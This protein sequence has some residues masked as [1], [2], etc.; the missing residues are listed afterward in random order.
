MRPIPAE[1][2]LRDED[3]IN[4]YVD[5]ISRIYLGKPYK[6]KAPLIPENLDY[7][8]GGYLQSQ[9]FLY[10]GCKPQ[11]IVYNKKLAEIKEFEKYVPVIH[12][13]THEAITDIFPYLPYVWDTP[14]IE[15]FTIYLDIKKAI[16][17]ERPDFAIAYY[18]NLSPEYK[19]YYHLVK[20]IDKELRKKGSSIEQAAKYYNE[21]AKNLLAYIA[22]VLASEKCKN[23]EP[24]N[25]K[26][27][28]S[29]LT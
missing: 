1:F 29:Y 19:G 11:K 6:P 5:E 20:Y 4:D 8:I 25:S 17:D 27:C 16:E 24:C 13:K 10:D 18:N 14:L 28:T 7:G 12:E 2:S 26:S 23:C 3:W 21:C 22:A 9:C 15:G